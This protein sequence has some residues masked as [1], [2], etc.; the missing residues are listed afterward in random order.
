MPNF[1][2][3]KGLMFVTIRDGTGL[4]QCVMSGL[5]AQTY[6]AVVLSL[7]STV[8]VYGT[9]KEVP[10]GKIAPNQHELIADFWEIV[11]LAPSE[12]PVNMESNPD[13]QLDQ[14]HLL[15]RNTTVSPILCA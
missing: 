13:T 8:C 4:M 10:V 6:E 9:L 1:I 2:K 5:L 7:E 15:L 3:G 12:L 11:Q 14:R